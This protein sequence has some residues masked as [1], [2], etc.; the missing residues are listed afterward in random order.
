MLDR[1]RNGTAWDNLVTIR[2]SNSKKDDGK[3]FVLIQDL[4]AVTIGFNLG[5][6]LYHQ[7]DLES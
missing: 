4:P 5:A 1:L 6:D 3:R 2:L 7:M